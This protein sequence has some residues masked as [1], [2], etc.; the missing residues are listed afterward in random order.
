MCQA[1]REPHE[2]VRLRE[3]HPTRARSVYARSKLIGE[4]LV[5]HLGREWGIETVALRYA[6]T[7]GPRQSLRNPYTGII[8][9]FSNRVRNGLP[10]IVYEDGL[11]T[12][13]FTYVED[14]AAANA[15]A[16]TRLPGMGPPV[17][18]VGTGVATTVLDVAEKIAYGRG[19]EWQHVVGYKNGPV[20]SGEFRPDDA[21]HIVTDPTQ[22]NM[23][24]WTAD[25]GIDAG[26]G[27]Y[28]EWLRSQPEVADVTEQ[29]YTRLR[30]E[31]VV[32]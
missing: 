13:D 15:F 8:S 16:A 18:N 7:Y 21:R 29:A 3:S 31:G 2:P 26:L 10:P 1:C 32:V 5:Q 17:L 19:L 11:Q 6:L 12:R 23:S 28:A 27:K 30:A 4:Q 25:V 22:F 20:L 14:V 9:I 24:G